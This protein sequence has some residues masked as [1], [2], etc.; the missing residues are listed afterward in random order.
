MPTAAACT[1]WK[2]R[3]AAHQCRMLRS[4]LALVDDEGAAPHFGKLQSR[5]RH[6]LANALISGVEVGKIAFVARAMRTLVGFLG[7]GVIVL[8]RSNPGRHLPV[9]HGGTAV[10][11]LVHV[12]PALA[13]GK[14][15]HSDLE[16]NPAL[17][18]RD[19]NRADFLPNACIGDAVDI[20]GEL[21]G[22]RDTR[23]DQQ[24]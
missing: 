6:G 8:S 11:L 24:G 13:L 16:R 22:E 17:G 4:G 21:L 10:T 1:T 12:E 18:L 9:L 7:I 3:A 2:P 14:A 15:G 19:C 5:S 20:D 23:R